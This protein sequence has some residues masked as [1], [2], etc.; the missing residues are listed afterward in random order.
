MMHVVGNEQMITKQD[1][2]KDAVVE[3]WLLA[4]AL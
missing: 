2:K 1:V 3:A 4:E